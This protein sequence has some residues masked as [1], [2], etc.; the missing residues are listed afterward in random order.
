LKTISVFRKNAKGLGDRR[1]ERVSRVAGN[2]IGG[3]IWS[4]MR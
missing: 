2:Q 4:F 1:R 3:S